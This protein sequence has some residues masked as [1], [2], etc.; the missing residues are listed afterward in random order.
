MKQKHSRVVCSYRG[1]GYLLSFCRRGSWKSPFQTTSEPSW[2]QSCPPPCWQVRWQMAQWV[3]FHQLYWY[4]HLYS[5]REEYINACAVFILYVTKILWKAGKTLC[6]FQAFDAIF[7]EEA[8]WRKNENKSL[9]SLL[10]FHYYTF[11][12]GPVCHS[13]KN[14]ACLNEGTKNTQFMMWRFRLA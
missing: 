1:W 14:L 2:S 12:A 7:N 13:P 4:L 3:A 9:P 5:E 6:I 11:P 8:K 10:P